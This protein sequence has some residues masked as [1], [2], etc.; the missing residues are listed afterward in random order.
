MTTRAA[1]VV[2]MIFRALIETFQI[3]QAASIPAPP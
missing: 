3:R 2:P 1:T